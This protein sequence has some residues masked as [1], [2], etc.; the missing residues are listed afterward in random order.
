MVFRFD[1][2]PVDVNDPYRVVTSKPLET[3]RVPTVSEMELEFLVAFADMIDL[4]DLI[5]RD[6]TLRERLVQENADLMSLARFDR[7]HIVRWGRDACWR[8]R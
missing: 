8:P 1:R 2:L 4:D 5:H 3:R 6:A 7:D